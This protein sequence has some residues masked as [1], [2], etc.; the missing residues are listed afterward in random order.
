MSDIKQKNN[1]KNHFSL[2]KEKK[3]KV[4]KNRRENEST[5][6]ERVN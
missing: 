5:F 1:N 4:K 3:T 2:F 6:L